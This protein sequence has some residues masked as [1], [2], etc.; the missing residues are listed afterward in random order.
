VG[1]SNEGGCAGGPGTRQGWRGVGAADASLSSPRQ[2]TTMEVVVSRGPG[3][4]GVA[5]TRSRG[6][7]RGGS[8]GGEVN[9]RKRGVK[10]RRLRHSVSLCGPWCRA[11]EERD[12]EG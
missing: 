8:E 9:E 11:E 5:S 3:G 7:A 12:G 1:V 2:V 6:V 10:R 4:N